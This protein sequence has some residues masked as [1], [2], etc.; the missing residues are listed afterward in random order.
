MSSLDKAKAAERDKAATKKK[1]EQEMLAARQ[2]AEAMLAVA[3]T[4]EELDTAAR[5][6]D[7]AC[8]REREADMA[9]TLSDEEPRFPHRLNRK[10]KPTPSEEEEE[11][12]DLGSTSDDH[13]EEEDHGPKEPLR[14]MDIE[15]SSEQS[16]TVTQEAGADQEPEGK[17][18]PPDENKNEWTE[19]IAKNK[20]KKKSEPPP[21]YYYQ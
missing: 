14:L 7:S 6:V 1:R 21:Q 10:R 15:R 20:T 2:A 5:A 3:E 18:R 19:V 4:P 16:S 9:S 13:E 12:S 11:D 8:R 17:E